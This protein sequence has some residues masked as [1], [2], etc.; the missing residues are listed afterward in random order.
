MHGDFGMVCQAMQRYLM[1]DIK[2]GSIFIIS[3]DSN[4]LAEVYQAKV[5][6][7]QLKLD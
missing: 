5:R 7:I 1:R 2:Q 4:L 3:N 6:S